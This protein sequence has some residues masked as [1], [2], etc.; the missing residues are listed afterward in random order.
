MGGI[1]SLEDDH[2]RIVNRINANEKNIGSLTKDLEVTLRHQGD[3]VEELKRK[4]IKGEQ[5]DDDVHDKLNAQE[6]AIKHVEQSL[7]AYQ[8]DTSRMIGEVNTLKSTVAF[9]ADKIEASYEYIEKIR[10]QQE[11]FEHLTDQNVGHLLLKVEN[12]DTSIMW[13]S[14]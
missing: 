14:R 4:I 3:N 11:S 6:N 5:N 13:L 2:K 9:L 8:N 10:Q 12:H 7:N 1:L